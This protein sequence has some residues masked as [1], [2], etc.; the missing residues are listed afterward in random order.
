M[1]FLQTAAAWDG[2]RLDSPGFNGSSE[3]FEICQYVL[4]VRSLS[5]VREQFFGTA[6][7]HLGN[8]GVL[9]LIVE[10]RGNFYGGRIENEESG[11]R[12]SILSISRVSFRLD[13]QVA[14]LLPAK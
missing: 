13:P 6:F 7:E 4:E 10:T 8:G 14:N 12:G 1:S 9:F 3:P 2:V 5:N 11:V